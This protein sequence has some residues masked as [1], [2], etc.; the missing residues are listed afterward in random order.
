MPGGMIFIDLTPMPLSK[1]VRWLLAGLAVFVVLLL[2]L[3]L[4]AERYVAPA[5]RERIG[6]LIVQGSD[7]LYTWRVDKLKASLF[8]G[9]V[10]IE[11]LHIDVDSNRYRRLLAEQRLPPL[12]LQVD[13]PYG[14]LRGVDVL[15]LLL[16]RNVR[17][18]EL[19]TQDARIGVWRNGREARSHWDRPPLWKMIR[20]GINSIVLKKLQLDGVRFAYRQANDSG[21]VQLKFD[22]CTAL[23]RDIRIDSAA[24]ADPGRIG[25]CRYVRLH[26]YDLKYRSADSAVKLKAKTID[27]SS[28]D[29]LLSITGFKM[30]PTL[31]DKESFYQA[32]ELQRQMT[33]IE[34]AR[35][36]LTQFRMEEFVRN[37]AIMAD[38]LLIDTPSIRIY[39]DKTLPPTLEGKMGRYPQQ[40]LQHSSTDVQIK[41]MALR[42][43]ALT[44]TERGE[45]SGEEGTLALERL[46][47]VAGNISNMPD[48]ISRDSTCRVHA[49]GSILRGSPLDVRFTFFLNEPEGRF[50]AE[51]SIRNVQASQLNGLAEPLAGIRLQSLDL[52]EL[53][54]RLQGDEYTARGEVGMRYR[55]LYLVLQKED[56]ET[57]LLKTKKFLTKLVNKY[58]LLHDNPGP[59][60]REAVAREVERSRLM[61]QTFFGFL[62]QAIFSGM[63]TIITNTGSS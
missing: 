40:L 63:Q 24:A 8:G 53:R 25:F 41:G 39:T 48:A 36:D 43:A 60:G 1:R 12:T 37:N 23:L 35:L 61:T 27:Y 45:K 33:V 50:N 59:D 26:F 54:F 31:K 6:V 42:G 13:M 52:Q 62:W 49:T 44:Y 57:G 9:R 51:G 10:T 21:D 15:N 2:A 3:A 18:G 19:F 32:T 55:N 28:E 11:G 38:S 47:I 30:Q 58:T 29:K 22:T 34:F 46:N 20:P 4:A 7:S 17:V 5:L 16:G 56:K 14:H